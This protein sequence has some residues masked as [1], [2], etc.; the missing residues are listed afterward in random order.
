MII[1]TANARDAACKSTDLITSGSVGIPVVFALSGDFDG[2]ACV[3]VFQGSGASVDVA[4]DSGGRCDVP[5]EVVAQPGGHIK[6]GVYGHNAQGTIVVP[7]VWTETTRILPGA[8]PSGFIPGPPTPDWA[9]QV[10]QWAR[11]A[12]EI[13][14]SVQGLRNRVT[15]LDTTVLA[16][17]G[18]V[19]AVGIPVYISDV[20]QHA[21]YGITESGWYT[22]ARI[23][24]P[25]G[26][27]VGDETT[28]T[29]A[30]GYIA[31]PGDD[32]VDVAARYGV[33]A[34]SQLVTIHWD[35]D[36]DADV[37]AFRATDLAVRN[38]D[39]RTTFYIYDLAPFVTWQ[40]A[41]TADAAFAEGKAY[42]TEADGVYALA[43][44][45]AADPVPA[46]YRLGED[47]ETYERATG[48]A[49][50]GVTYYTAS[51]DTYSP[52]EL[53]VGEPIPAYYNHSK[54]HIEGMAR[55]I[56]Y[57]LDTP[58]DCPSEIALPTIEDD[59]HGAWFEMRFRHTGRFSSVLLP[60][61]PDVKVATEHTQ[62]ETAGVNMVDLHYVSIGGEKIWRFMNTHSTIPT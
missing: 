26:V 18:I 27:T 20:T 43:E 2:L 10:Q 9:A 33:A 60:E 54:L 13:A 21:A 58:V 19:E 36:T 56:T 12:I 23:T 57:Q 42:Y 49:L 34:M 45:T 6:I 47:G 50:E 46:Y 30:A 38:L 61:D 37:I 52:A 29:G 17:G 14:R 11:E 53:P 15:S 41:L 51:G 7:T 16:N 25:D 3:A 35:A 22:F 40:Y 24:A 28:V 39:Y 32:H 55:N 62:A 4:L 31:I 8:K 1:V 59:G 48:V 44:V 5:P